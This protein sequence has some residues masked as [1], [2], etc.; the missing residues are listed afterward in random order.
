MN[1]FSCFSG[2]GGIDLAAE[3]AGFTI[4]GQVEKAD[5]PFRVLCRHWPDV[6][7]WRDVYDVTGNII[8]RA[9]GEQSPT[10]LSGGFPCQPFSYAG[11]QRGKD[12]DRYLWP[13]LFRLV[14]ECR[15]SWFV[16]ENVVGIKDMALDR[17]ITDLESIGYTCRAFDIPACAVGA[18]HRRQRIFVVAHSDSERFEELDATTVKQGSGFCG[19]EV[20][21]GGL[22]WTIESPVGRVADGI[23]GRVDRLRCLGNAVVPQQVFPILN[24][25]AK[26]ELGA[27]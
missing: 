10:L 1:H 20:D 13:E 7:K 22:Q 23:S 14:R 17:V 24:S 11:K 3:W 6:P 4:V 9:C 16:G 25:I 12:D 5:Y 27:F 8:R 21:S 2:I 18:D 26:I 15:P 19:W